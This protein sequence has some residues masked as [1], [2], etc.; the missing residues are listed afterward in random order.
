MRTHLEERLQREID[1]I[2]S[3]VIQMG[4]LAENALDTC[5]QAIE[6]GNRQLAYHVILR[7]RY[8]DE[9][10]NEL[11][12]L[13][14]KFLIKEQPAAG[15]MRFV[16]GVIKINNELERIG[17]Y[18]ESI[19]RQF[20]AASSIEPQPSYHRIVEIANLASPLLRDALRAFV[21]QDAELAKA[22]RAKEKEKSIDNLRN[23]IHSDLVQLHS[24]G[25][26]P[27]EALLPLMT[28]A[29]RFER[30][31]DQAGNICEE[32]LYMSTGEEIKHKNKQVLRV[33]FVD[34]DDAC[35]GQMA[36][37]IGNTVGA[38]GIVFSSA[39]ATA[40]PVDPKTVEFMAEKGIDI[41]NQ[42]SR[43]LNEAL[44]LKN[45]EAIISLCEEAER[46]L[47]ALPTKTVHISWEVQDASKVEDVAGDAHAAYEDAFRYLDTNIRAFVEAILGNHTE[48]E[49]TDVQ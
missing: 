35:R 23:D 41:S 38:P 2:R 16:Y 48:A 18:A 28:I 14:Q 43:Y 11:D 49:E 21:E 46:A 26:L 22:T 17:D 7:D 3:K 24:S 40:C 30:V 12:W 42:T 45:Y 33:L 6:D 29:N 37:G 15:H 8:I 47:P 27:S 31:A 10:E 4:E 5:V 34:V 39:G 36:Q 25:D 44:E 20:L 9:L 1:T 19:A 32:V 13:C